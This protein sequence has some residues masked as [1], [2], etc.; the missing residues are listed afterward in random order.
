[1]RN[2]FPF[3]FVCFD[4]FHTLVNVAAAPGGTGRYTADILGL[5][6]TAWRD[7][8]FGHRHV[9]T[10]PTVHLDVIRTLA[11]SLNPE[12]TE[13]AIAEATAE[14]Q[15]RFDH[16]LLNI[17]PEVLDT[18][19]RLR[20]CGSRLA[21]ISNASS[22]EIAAWSGSPL[23]PLFDA[24]VFSCEC[25]W[26]KPQHEIY[27]EALR[28]LDADASATLYVGDGGSDELRGARDVGLTPVWISRHVGGLTS[29]Q[30]AQRRHAAQRHIGRLSEL[31]EG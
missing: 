24:V 29:Q 8:C 16:A 1:M 28:R 9:I 23:A 5:G 18:L 25:G 22:G 17:E 4:L 15:R 11:H 20:R 7:A 21:L 26:R 12:I 19:V 13:A 10:R 31:L 27:H 3:P 2:K 14:R 6:R 30:L